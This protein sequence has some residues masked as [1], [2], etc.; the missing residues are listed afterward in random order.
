MSW[1]QA[2]R[3]IE[4][5]LDPHKIAADIDRWGTDWAHKKHAA[6]V[7]EKTTSATLAQLT[8]E[9]RRQYPEM[10][11]KE[12]EDQAK[13]G[14]TYLDHLYAA[15]D[16]RRDSNLARVHYDAA[17]ARFEALRSM[18][19]TRRTEMQTLSRR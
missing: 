8:N 3:T 17:M 2:S 15:A 18:E 19:A 10:S 13:G 12:A 4:G 14:Q 1:D 11:R 6:D 7:L 5:D 16:A 9:V